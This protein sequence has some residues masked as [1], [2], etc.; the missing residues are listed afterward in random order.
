M[1][2]VRHF[3]GLEQHPTLL[4]APIQHPIKDHR[5]P[6]K[7]QN[8]IEIFLQDPVSR[9]YL[10]NARVQAHLGQL[11][12]HPFNIV[13]NCL[14]NYKLITYALSDPA[15]QNEEIVNENMKEH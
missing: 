13:I 4:L 6:H 12:K 7:E 2:P 9:S 5:N 10:I 14:L 1:G 8:S 11:A 15:V 3:E